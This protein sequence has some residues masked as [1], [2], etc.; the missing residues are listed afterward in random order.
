MTCKRCGKESEEVLCKDCKNELKKV[1]SRAEVSELQHLMEKQSD[2]ENTKELPNL[3]EL[4]EEK[5]DDVV[6][7]TREE[8]LQ[9]KLED[10]K[11][12]KSKKVWIIIL[13]VFAVVIVLTIVLVLFFNSQKEEP[14]E[15]VKL[16]YEKIL[17]TYGSLV[18]KETTKYIED[19]KEVPTWQ[20]ITDII[21]Y[22]DYEI[23]CD[24]H[25]I[26][27]DGKVYLKDCKINGK[28]VKYT[29]GEEQEEKEGKKIEI[30]SFTYENGIKSFSNQKDSNS[31]LEGEI[32]CKTESCDYVDGYNDYVLIREENKYYIYNYKNNSVEF[33]PFDIKD[34]DQLDLNI[35]SGNNTLYGIFYSENGANNIYSLVASK[36]F[37]NVKGDL[38][39]GYG[40]GTLY[41]HN[42]AILKYNGSNNFVNLKTGNVSFT[43]KE[44][45]SHFLEDSQNKMV[46]ILTYNEKTSKYKL[47]NTTGKLLFDGKEFADVKLLDKKL[48]VS[49]GKQF[50]T[51]DSKLNLSVTSKTYDEV[52]G[53]FDDFVVV[54]SEGKL[55]IVNSSDKVIAKFESEWDS[56][57]YLHTYLSGWQTIDGKYGIYLI[58]ENK[59]L[60]YGEQGAGYK[61]YY[62][63]STSETGVIETD[64]VP[65]YGIER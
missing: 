16:N 40:V 59:A 56:N 28:K 17:N 31:K 5:V 37:K 9:E 62:I 25:S 6:L 27:K 4:V 2:L 39:T 52:L 64:G 61:F 13:I 8:R 7:E 33:G 45:I 55:Q 19:K 32:T 26:Y 11:D 48:C 38:I 42:Y 30:Y 3:S 15:E 51:Y 23:S 20:A 49:D 65:G 22:K 46:Y 53:I 54:V 21:D 58:V 47:Y 24:T 12:K 34:N 10:Q 18:E 14:V 60:A 29:Y 36:T 63:K 50:K 41:K 43:I 57:Y 44:S 35:I 1:S